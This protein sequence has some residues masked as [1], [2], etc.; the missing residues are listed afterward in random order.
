MSVLSDEK[1]AIRTLGSHIC[2]LLL[3]SLGQKWEPLLLPQLFNT[4]SQSEVRLRAIASETIIELFAQAQDNLPFLLHILLSRVPLS[5]QEAV[6]S[7]TP[8]WL[9]KRKLPPLNEFALEEIVSQCC[10]Q[11][12]DAPHLFGFARK[13]AV[14][15]HEREDY[16]TMQMWV[17]LLL[18]RLVYSNEATSVVNQLAPFLL[19]R[20]FPSLP[21]KSLETDTFERLIQC[22]CQT[23][24][25]VNTKQLSDVRRVCIEVLARLDSSS[26]P[27]NLFLTILSSKSDTPTDMQSA[28]MQIVPGG[29]K[30]DL[31]AEKMDKAALFG[32]C[33]ILTGNLLRN[34]LGVDSFPNALVAQ[35]LLPLLDVKVDLE[36]G[37]A[38]YFSLALVC[39]GF[40]A[41]EQ[42]FGKHVLDKPVKVEEVE[43]Q[44]QQQV[45]ALEEFPSFEM[46]WALW[47]KNPHAKQFACSVL[48]LIARG[49]LTPKEGSP[50]TSLIQACLQQYQQQHLHTNN[51]VARAGWGFIHRVLFT[52]LSQSERESKDASSYFS[53]AFTCCFVN[54]RLFPDHSAL[55]SF[56]FTQLMNECIHWLGS[57]VDANK[58]LAIRLVGVLLTFPTPVLQQLPDGTLGRVQVLLSGISHLDPS[59]EARVLS[60]EILKSFDS[61]QQSINT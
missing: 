52:L 40:L 15:A 19:L 35:V 11:A 45:V 20:V 29:G 17:S 31:E 2:V 48:I 28:L 14:F 6:F 37:L 53:L 54:M 49:F 12:H 18:P 24:F 16:A 23:S 46:V 27:W 36:P 41:W 55:D 26:L 21:P 30:F 4:V 43:E 57:S 47:G 13:V 7:L 38:D 8:K 1:L 3:L 22:L 61:K 25:S 42:L 39:E 32:C 34:N 44:Q 33:Q 50:T 60:S 10:A 51:R 56:A 59:S 58:A 9:A 5:Q